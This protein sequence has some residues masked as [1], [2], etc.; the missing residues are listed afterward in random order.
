MKIVS[1][2]WSLVLTGAIF[3]IAMLASPTPF[4]GMPGTRP[5]IKQDSPVHARP[6]FDNIDRGRRIAFVIEAKGSML[7]KWACLKEELDKTIG[8]LLPEQTFGMVFFQPGPCDELSPALLPASSANK[9]KATAFLDSV[10]VAGY[11]DPIPGIEAAF[12]EKADILYLLADG[13]FP[14][15]D[16]VVRKIRELNS[17]NRVRVYTIAFMGDADTDSAFIDLFKMIASETRGQ[18]KQVKAGDL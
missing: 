17:G 2:F 16:A 14:D 8:G 3:P 12:K 15:N 9:K 1:R 6:V 13:D 4:P 7:V 10:T 11:T 5:S 18:F